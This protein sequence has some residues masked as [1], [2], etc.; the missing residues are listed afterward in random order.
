MLS[1]SLSYYK[2][3]NYLV[4]HISRKGNWHERKHISFINVTLCVQ[5]GLA[6]L[7]SKVVN[8]SLS[9]HHS[10]VL[11]TGRYTVAN[12]TCK[13]CGNNLGWKYITAAEESQK[14][15]EGRYLIERTQV[16]KELQWDK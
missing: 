13:I 14:Y 10:R 7:T 3:R 6:Y 1:L 12:V 2:L 4:S 5:H 15:K 8:V 11:L 9:V 16:V